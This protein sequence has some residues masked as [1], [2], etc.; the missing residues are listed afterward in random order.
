MDLTSIIISIVSSIIIAC[1]SY[2]LGKRTS[3]VKTNKEVLDGINKAN[4]VRDDLHSDVD[5]FN[6]LCKKYH[7]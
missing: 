7:R 1:L 5:K 3:E 2:K 6:E 4:Q